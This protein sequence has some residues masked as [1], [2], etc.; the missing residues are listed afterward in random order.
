MR[1]VSLSS[2]IFPRGDELE[3]NEEGLAF[4]DA[5]IDR[6]N[7]L[8]LV[9]V[10]TLSHYEMPLTLITEYGGWADRRVQ[11][12]FNRYATTVVERYAGEVGYW[13]GFNQINSGLMDP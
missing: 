7:D 2:R 5:L 11:D 12:F 6:M 13:M 4:Y 9:P 1:L 3:P 10:I 8:G